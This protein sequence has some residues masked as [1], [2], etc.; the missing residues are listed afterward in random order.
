MTAPAGTR[1]WSEIAPGVSVCHSALYAT[2]STVVRSG[3]RVLLV[4]PAWRSD[5]LS[6]LANDLAAWGVTVTAGFATHAHHDHLLWHPGFGHV[7]RHASRAA[8]ALAVRERAALVEN[9]GPAFDPI[10]VDLMGRVTP[11]AG[12]DCT[13]DPSDTAELDGWPGVEFVIHDAHS[14]GHAAVWLPGPRVLLAGDMLSDV[15]IPLAGETGLDAYDAGLTLLRPYVERAAVLI[16]GHGSPTLDPRP[17][18][19]ADRHYLDAVRSGGTL[20]ADQDA[21]LADQDNM[22]AH[23]E[24]VALVP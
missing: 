11:P 17:R 24:N 23:A 10:L 18:W 12:L 14:S 8:A 4:D 9:L 5:E 21:R 19:T 6:A 16:P 15:E 3:D 13:G 20:T 22:T 2:A 1:A 7:P